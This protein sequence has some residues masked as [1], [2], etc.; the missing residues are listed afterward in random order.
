MS[1]YLKLKSPR[2]IEAFIKEAEALGWSISELADGSPALKKVEIT[3]VAV[4]ISHHK[5]PVRGLCCYG[6]NEFGNL[7][8]L[9]KL[10]PQ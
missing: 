7:T 8:T 1:T 2:S 10:P 4:D 9:C 3:Y 6:K 5:K